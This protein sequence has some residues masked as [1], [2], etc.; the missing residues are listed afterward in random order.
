MELSNQLLWT[1]DAVSF[2]AFLWVAVYLIG[3]LFKGGHATFTI[4]ASWALYGL[5]SM[6]WVILRVTEVIHA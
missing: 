3:A 4:P 6:T 2:F 1:L 5:L